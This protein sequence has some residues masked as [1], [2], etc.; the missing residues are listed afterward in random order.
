MPVWTWVGM[1]VDT[2]LVASY[3]VG[4]RGPE[5]AKDFMLD[6][7]SRM[8]SRVQLTTDGHRP[9]LLAVPNAFQNDVDYRLLIK[10]LRP[11]DV[12]GEH[13]LLPGCLPR[14]GKAADDRQP[15][16]GSHLNELRRA[17]EPH[18]AH[19]HAPVHALDQRF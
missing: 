15:R 19:E 5:D 9:Y 2:K 12:R 4:G 6:L 18:H 1:D 7:A 11:H 17:A 13:A 14:T 10:V 8:K 3:H 16:P